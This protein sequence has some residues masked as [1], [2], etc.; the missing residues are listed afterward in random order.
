MRRLEGKVAIITGGGGAIGRA[1]AARLASEGA[2]VVVADLHA[3]AAEA[4]AADVRAAGGRAMAVQVDV[5]DETSVQAL[6][7]RAVEAFSRIDILHN[8]AGILL[9]G[10]AADATLADW[11]RSIAVN[12]TGAFLCSK[13]TIPVML[14]NGGGS[15]VHTSSTSGLV[16]EPNIA[17]YCASKGAVLM[18]AKQMS[19]DYARQGI[20]VN[21]ICPG[22]IDTAF[23]DPVVIPA[24]GKEALAPFIDV[25]VPMGRQGQPEEIADAVAFLASDDSRL[26]TGAVLVVDGG[27]TAQ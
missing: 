27:L 26:M 4:V 7:E 2:A 1:T 6:V 18:L 15:I 21:A 25:F 5:T 14:R 24:G 17:A 12:A 10:S 22:W 3:G 8:N 20:R 19:I 23:N 9:P 13:H 16:G 11:N